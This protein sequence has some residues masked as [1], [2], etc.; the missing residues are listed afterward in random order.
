MA[1]SE[2]EP[3]WNPPP[4]QAG[5][6]DNQEGEGTPES[7]D[8]D[9]IGDTAFSKSWVLSM[10]VKAVALVDKDKE[11]APPEKKPA[12]LQIVD[13]ERVLDEEIETDLCRLLDASVNEVCVCCV[14]VCVCGEI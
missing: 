11:G 10:L 6:G 7:P 3:Q 13:R 4:P 9:A 14:C 12:F 2:S 8:I 1:A 5:A